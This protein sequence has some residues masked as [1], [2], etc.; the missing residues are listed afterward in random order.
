MKNDYEYTLD[1]YNHLMAFDHFANII[2]NKPVCKHGDGCKAFV[3]M[4]NNGDKRQLNRFDDKCHLAIY[5]HP[6][7]NDRQ[8][9]MAQ[10]ANRLMIIDKANK[11]Q[12]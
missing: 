3:R 12:E 1:N 4:Q 9:K 7:R 8:L 6:P 11:V 5:K 10:N 2:A